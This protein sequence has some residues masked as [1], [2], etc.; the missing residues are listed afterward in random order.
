MTTTGSQPTL[1]FLHALKPMNT[2]E[3]PPKSLKKIFH[4][5]ILA[6]LGLGLAADIRVTHWGDRYLK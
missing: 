5:N 2:A 1:M 6:M 4:I 3:L